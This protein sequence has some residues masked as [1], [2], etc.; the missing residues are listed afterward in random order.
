MGTPHHQPGFPVLRRFSFCIHAIATT[1]AEPLGVLRSLPQPRRPSP[2]LR[3]VGFHITLFEACSAFT[4][5][6]GLYTRQATIMT[7]YTRGSDCFVTSAATPIATGWSDSCRVGISPTEEPRLSRRTEISGL[8]PTRESFPLSRFSLSWQH[9]QVT[10]YRH[11]TLPLSMDLGKRAVIFRGLLKDPIE[12]R[13]Q[14]LAT[15]C[16]MKGVGP[17]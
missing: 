1:P 3:R 15:L 2:K 6:Y 12:L 7:L 11:R 13:Y 16:E 17:L 8:G 4:T 9:C 5:R 10:Q 14:E